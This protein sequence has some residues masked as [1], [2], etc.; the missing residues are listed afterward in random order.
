MKRRIWIAIAVI[1][2][3]AAVAVACI[4]GYVSGQKE[5]EP[6]SPATVEPDGNPAETED[7]ENPDDTEEP[8]VQ[9]GN[10]N[11]SGGESVVVYVPDEQ[12]ETLTPVGT[13]AEDDSDQAL[14]DA[15]ITA[16]SLPEGVAVNSSSTT[17]GV[18]TLDM[19]AAYGDAVRSS[20]T[21]GEN[22]L[23]YSLVNTFVQARGVDSVIITVDGAPL[24][25][26]HEIYDYPLQAT[27]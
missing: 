7:P 9:P 23:I 19:N 4:F 25:S 21:T 11:P 15:L 10:P 17:D 6:E 12:G 3:I 13:D 18:L 24:E 20:G 1:V 22:M 2:I 26:G 8:A 14:V 27:N 16:G 5:Q